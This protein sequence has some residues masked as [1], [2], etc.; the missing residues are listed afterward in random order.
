MFQRR[1]LSSEISPKLATPTLVSYSNYNIDLV[2]AIDYLSMSLIGDWT[3][4]KESSFG[5]LDSS[6]NYVLKILG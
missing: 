2:F 4:K 3:L 1:L 5:K 6:I